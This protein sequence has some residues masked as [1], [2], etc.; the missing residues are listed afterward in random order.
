MMIWKKSELRATIPKYEE[1][2][3]RGIVQEGLYH[4]KPANI[5]VGMSEAELYKELEVIHEI[6]Q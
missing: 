6:E 5:K 2:T 1:E 4:S 3:V